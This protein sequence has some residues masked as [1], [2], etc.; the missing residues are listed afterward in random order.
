LTWNGNAVEYLSCIDTL[1]ITGCKLRYTI[2]GNTSEITLYI[3]SCKDVVVANNDADIMFKLD[4]NMDFYNTSTTKY[5]FTNNN[6]GCQRYGGIYIEDLGGTIKANE[7]I[8]IAN[9]NFYNSPKNFAP[10]SAYSF[11]FGGTIPRANNIDIVITNN[12]AKGLSSNA[13]ILTGKAN[14]AYMVKNNIGI[15]DLA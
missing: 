11:D 7:Q 2:T 6:I 4:A 8:V 10:A 3:Q 9:N 1:K 13:S 15:A 12:N 5:L 14:I